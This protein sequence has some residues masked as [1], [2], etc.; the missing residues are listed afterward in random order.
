M[1]DSSDVSAKARSLSSVFAAW[2][3]LAIG[4]ILAVAAWYFSEQ[5]VQTNARD[6]FES[7]AME[8]TSAIGERMTGY[9]QVLWGTVGLFNSSNNVDRSE[10]RTYV[11][12]L[13]IQEH[14]PGIQGIGFSIPVN[15][16][17]K[18]AH[19]AAIRAEGFTDYAVKPEGDR[20]EYSAIIYLEPFDWRNKRAFGYD[21][22]S[23]DMRRDA[24]TRARDYGVASTSGMITLVQETS[25]DVQKGFLTYLPL[26]RQGAPTGTIEQR[27]AAFEGWVY[28]PFRMGDLMKGILGPAYTE[29]NYEIFDGQTLDK[30]ILLFDSNGV[31][32]TDQPERVR[33][34]EFDTTL[35]LQGRIWRLHFTEDA[36]PL[37]TSE[38]N[39]PLVILLSGL[40]VTLLTFFIVYTLAM[41]Q[42]RAESI[43]RGMTSELRTARELAEAANKA[44]SEFLATMSHEIR[45]PMTAVMGFSDLLLLESLPQQSKEKVGKIKDATHSLLIIINDILDISKMEVGKLK[46]EHTD[47]DI[48]ALVDDTFTM[49]KGGDGDQSRPVDLSYAF[50][51]DFP[52]RIRSDATRIRQVLVNLVGN[53]VKF[54]AEGEVRLEGSVRKAPDG[55]RLLHFTIIDT[56]IGIPENL[57]DSLFADFTQA[58]ASMSRKFEGTGLGLSIC[59]RLVTLMDGDIGVESQEGKGSAFWFTIPW[60]E[61][62][63]QMN[64]QP[65]PVRAADAKPKAARSLNVLIAEDNELNQQVLKAVVSGL[66]HRVDLAKDGAEMVSMHTDGDY[67]L[68]LSDIRMPNV[69]GTD[70]TKQIRQMN[71]DKANIPIIAITADLMEENKAGYFAAGMNGIAS[72][73]LDAR[74]LI[75]VIQTVMIEKSPDQPRP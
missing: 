65:D 66:G 18:P 17:D 45:T 53:A 1:V 43:A 23:N 24:M 3:V 61:P 75:D 58:D 51:D 69:S 39:L 15:P 9:E 35:E 12:S 59:K 21:M 62:H 27:R 47:F 49:F 36:Y 11:E 10:F 52:M 14:W 28:S 68:I 4:C 22:W 55:Q 74:E 26:Y 5:F 73:P 72:K 31:F 33:A 37:T 25:D 64:T 32:H 19:E 71:G 56:G 40:V 7:L 34:V 20:S 67:D 38:K 63:E 16:A 60:M 46:I 54:T 30:D 6:R 44:K 13:S 42:R 29:F 41:T 50:S 8:I 48:R 70:A 2:V 57:V